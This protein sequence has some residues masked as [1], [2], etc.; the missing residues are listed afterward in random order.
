MVISM[1]MVTDSKCEV[2]I[3]SACGYPPM[4]VTWHWFTAFIGCSAVLYARSVPGT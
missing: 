2:L 4:P 3:K 1:T